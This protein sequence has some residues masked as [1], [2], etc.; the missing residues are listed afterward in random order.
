M[1]FFQAF[2]GSFYSPQRYQNV[3]SQPGKGLAYSA[4]LVCLT[5]LLLTLYA[6]FT[7]HRVLFVAEGGQLPLFDDV[8]RQIATQMPVMDYAGGTLSTRDGKAH[9]IVVELNVLG[10]HHKGVLATV[11]T[12]GNTTYETMRGPVL[13]G[14]REII[15]RSTDESEIKTVREIIGED[16]TSLTITPELSEKIAEEVAIEVRANATRIYLYIGSFLW[17][18]LTP[19][20]Y[21][22]RVLMLAALALGSMLLG[23]GLKRPVDFSASMRLAALSFTPVTVCDNLSLVFY[24]HPLDSLHLLLCGGIM[25]G[26]ALLVTRQTPLAAA[27]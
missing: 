15:V 4:L 7:F 25:L 12:T 10:E 5:T 27:A 6:C 19:I 8:L 23:M 9:D 17:L 16:V 3:R 18:I 26:A 13:I 1:K 24:H 14:A 11:D 21:V 2:I 22:M 20:L